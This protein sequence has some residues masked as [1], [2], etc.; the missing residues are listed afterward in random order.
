MS[1]R[2]RLRAHPIFFA[3]AL[4]VPLVSVIAALAVFF[5]VSDERRAGQVLSRLL[6]ERV[7]Y[8]VRIARA[9]TDG[10]SY[11]VL[12]GI[13]VPSARESSGD[14]SI[15]EARI[16]GPL[17][18]LL[19]HPSGQHLRIRV[20]S[21]SVHL[22]SAAGPVGLPPASALDRIRHL[23][24]RLVEWPASASFTLT[25]GEVRI[26]DE[27]TH[28]DLAGEKSADGDVELRLT[29]RSDAGPSVIIEAMG[30]LTD[31][32]LVVDLTAEG[33]PRALGEVWSTALPPIRHLSASATLRLP[34]PRLLDLAGH[35]MLTPMADEPPVSLSV[36]ASYY[37]DENRVDLSEVAAT[38]GKIVAVEG[39]GTAEALARSPRLALSLQGSA[40]G[41]SLRASLELDTAERTVSS[42]VRLSQPELRRWLGRFRLSG[43]LPKD[44]EARADHLRIA[45][46][47]SWLTDGSLGLRSA[48]IRAE[49]ER[50]SVSVGKLE[51][52]SPAVE[53]SATAT[54]GEEEGL[55]TE[56]SLQARRVDGRLNGKTHRLAVSAQ[57]RVRL[58]DSAPWW[59]FGAP[60]QFRVALSNSAGAPIL[61]ATGRDARERLLSQRELTLEVSLPDLAGL[62]QLIPGIIYALTGSAE[63]DGRLGWSPAGAV[64]F[65]GEVSL[66]V[67]Q[68]TFPE[69]D[70]TLTNLTGAFPL[71]HG[72]TG[73]IPWG[74]I[75]AQSLTAYGV[76][77]HDFSA[78]AQIQT[79]FLNLLDAAYAHYGGSGNGW[80]QADFTDPALPIRTRFEATGVDLGRFVAE[81]GTQTAKISGQ[82]RY[83]VG[84]IHTRPFGL[85]L[86]GELHVGPPGGVLSI[87]VLRGLL[88]GA[89]VGPLGMVRDTLEKLSE[90]RYRSL[91]AQLHMDQQETRVSLSLRGRKRF[92]IF[93]PRI[94]AINIENL[95]LSRV[96]R[97]LGQ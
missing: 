87:D 16:D 96:A 25:G 36:S 59:G 75:A 58:T 28:F 64:R 7:G 13:R 74:S 18:R 22:A 31:D 54:P 47:A 41:R 49:L 60:E 11:L 77:F 78:R 70:A 92:G 71:W 61:R 89:P 52:S 19:V 37:P 72:I 63:L 1:L 10:T 67:P 34:G 81:Y 68:A 15:R 8:P 40:E 55:L 66:R 88:A 85:E 45:A 23:A 95:P 93:P 91:S 65:Q 6:T 97:I 5:V 4:C 94:K 62:P 30:S 3:I 35:V 17:L 12:V 2:S 50:A 42:V 38:W 82:A 57:A 9:K 39:S 56:S 24:T 21:T 29:A 44:L 20:V 27:I 46:E 33:D 43:K 53:F 69:L 79:G 80:I 83:V 14:L 86:G 32:V 73:A 48:H 90:F 84:L 76:A 26:R 51:V